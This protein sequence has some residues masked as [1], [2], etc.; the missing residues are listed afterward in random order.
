M[1]E[2]GIIFMGTWDNINRIPWNYGQVIHPHTDRLFEWV[3]CVCVYVLGLF[4][5]CVCVNCHSSARAKTWRL[6]PVQEMCLL[7]GG[8]FWTGDRM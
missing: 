5:A 7:D 4:V 1:N 8:N 6:L 3:N 2:D